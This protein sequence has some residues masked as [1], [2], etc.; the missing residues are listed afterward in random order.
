MGEVYRARD[1]KL[2]REVAIKTLPDAFARDPERLARFRREAQLFA[3]LNHPNI[4]A[5]YGLEESGGV[6]F[7]VLELVLGETLAERLRGS[8]GSRIATDRAGA[9]R[10]GAN[11]AAIVRERTDVPAIVRERPETA[12][13]GL[14]LEDALKIALQIAEAMEAAHERSIVH[15]DLKPAN[16]KITPEEKVKVLDFGLA[17]AFAIQLPTCNLQPANL[18]LS[19]FDLYGY[20]AWASCPC[21]EIFFTGEPPMPRPAR[22]TSRASTAAS[23]G[24]TPT[25]PGRADQSALADSATPLKA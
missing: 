5:I 18:R 19:T 13:R 4:A 21:A 16:I 15:R 22:D 23:C 12:T 25:R 11:R 7:L 24:R 2:G 8:T 20:V 6:Q 17:K 14:P 9:N 3:S 1:T 10:V